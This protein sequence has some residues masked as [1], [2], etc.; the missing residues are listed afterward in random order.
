M[1]PP[2]KKA[3]NLGYSRANDLICKPKQTESKRVKERR[4][5]AWVSMSLIIKENNNI[6]MNK[7]A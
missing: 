5:D 7:K 6:P 1:A 3:K 4:R 2:N